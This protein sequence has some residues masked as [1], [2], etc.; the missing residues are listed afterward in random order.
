MKQPIRFK[1]DN[2]INDLKI[3]Y[4]MENKLEVIEWDDVQNAEDFFIDLIEVL[5][6]LLNNNL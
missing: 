2:I 3:K 4:C 1:V 6:E 5:T